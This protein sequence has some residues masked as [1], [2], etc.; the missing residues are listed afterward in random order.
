MVNN[1]FA[2]QIDTSRF[3]LVTSIVML[4]LSVSLCFIPMYDEDVS[5]FTELI[6]NAL[7]EAAFFLFIA[8][9]SLISL[10]CVFL[11]AKKSEYFVFGNFL[12]LAMYF[13]FW[14]WRNGYTPHAAFYLTVIALVFLIG[15]SVY[16][17]FKSKDKKINLPSLVLS[18]VLLAMSFFLIFIPTIRANYGQG[19]SGISLTLFFFSP[20]SVWFMFIIMSVLISLAAVVLSQKD[21]RFMLLNIAFPVV[22]L[23]EHIIFI[24]TFNSDRFGGMD[25][26]YPHAAFYLCVVILFFLIGYAIYLRKTHKP[27]R[28]NKDGSKTRPLTK[29]ERIAEL[30]RQLAELSVKGGEAVDESQETIE[31]TTS[32]Q[33]VS[34]TRQDKIKDRLKQIPKRGYALIALAMVIVLVSIIVP[35]TLTNDNRQL[36]VQD[37]KEYSSVNQITGQRDNRVVYY[38][39]FT[40]KEPMIPT[41]YDIIGRGGKII[42]TVNIYHGDVTTHGNRTFFYIVLANERLRDGRRIVVYAKSESTGKI[43]KYRLRI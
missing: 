41:G 7:S 13:S 30:E 6:G 33:T 16:L 9:V 26:V 40:S 12:P 32:E 24:S 39:Y 5:I 31:P 4:V 36:K 42:N 25:I 37:K 28:E 34:E 10:V 43:L 17:F 20:F 29:K 18:L 19:A 2:K 3:A 21:G 11:T 35:V 23:I 38:V 27:N 15:Y 22:Y 8:V 14:D 1:K